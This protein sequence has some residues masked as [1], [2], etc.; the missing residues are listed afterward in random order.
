M[1]QRSRKILTDWSQLVFQDRWAAPAF[2]VPKK[3]GR[4]RFVS[5]F[6]WLNKMIKCM[7]YPLPHIKDMLLKVTHFIY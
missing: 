7:P 6:R 5:D 4:V 1:K 2:I 3:D